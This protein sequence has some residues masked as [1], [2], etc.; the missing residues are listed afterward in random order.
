M[1]FAQSV[2]DVFFCRDIFH[3]FVNFDK[4]VGVERKVS[5]ANRKIFRRDFSDFFVQRTVAEYVDGFLRAVDR[6]NAAFCQKAET[7]DFAQ[8]QIV[9]AVENADSFD[10]F[11]GFFAAAF[12]Q[13]FKNRRLNRRLVVFFQIFQKVFFAGF[14]SNLTDSEHSGFPYLFVFVGKKRGGGNR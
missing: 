4:L 8:N 6:E 13:G 12:A 1:A 9:V 2:C 5:V 3:R 11:Q 14:V 10:G 7:F